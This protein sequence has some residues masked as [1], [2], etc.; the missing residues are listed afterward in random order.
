MNR[1]EIC[2][3]EIIQKRTFQNYQCKRALGMRI[4]LSHFKPLDNNVSLVLPFLYS[5]CMSVF[6]CI[7]TRKR[8]IER[9]TEKREKNTNNENEIKKK[10]YALTQQSNGM[11]CSA[12]INS[13]LH[14]IY[15][16]MCATILH[17]RLE[18]LVFEHYKIEW[19]CVCLREFS[20]CFFFNTVPPRVL[21]SFVCS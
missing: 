19:K 2:I 9:E 7:E 11:F 15:K 4:D 10:E 13:D 21:F 20:I 6:I 5:E 8:A 3:V 18:I 1:N 17:H 12:E 16:I 14:F